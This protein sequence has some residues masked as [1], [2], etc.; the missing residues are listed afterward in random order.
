MPV[1]LEQWRI[2]TREFRENLAW[3]VVVPGDGD[4]SPAVAQ[5]LDELSLRGIAIHNSGL[6]SW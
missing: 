1:A 2:C 3:A 4:I 5:L 6:D